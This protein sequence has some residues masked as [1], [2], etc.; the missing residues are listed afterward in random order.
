[1]YKLDYR[2]TFSFSVNANLHLK[3]SWFCTDRFKCVQ[4]NV[5]IIT[6]CIFAMG[7]HN[8]LNI[9]INKKSFKVEHR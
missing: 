1:M 7:P 9:G 8:A 2:G 3:I 5:T 4:N 6:D